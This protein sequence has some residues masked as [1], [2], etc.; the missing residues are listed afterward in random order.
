MSHFLF[1]VTNSCSAACGYCYARERSATHASPDSLEQIARGLLAETSIDG[2]T[3]IGGE[4]LE[5]PDIVDIAKRLTALG[6]PL[7][8][9]TNGLALDSSRLEA[10]MAAGLRTFE[11]SL[12]T[13]DAEIFTALGRGP[14]VEVVKHR[15]AELVRS[16][17]QVTVSAVLSRMNL[18]GIGDLVEFCFAVGATGLSLLRVLRPGDATGNSGL[19][20]TSEAL[21]EALLRCDERAGALDFP[22][23]CSIPVEPCYFPTRKLEHLVLPACECGNSKWVVDPRGNLRTCELSSLKLGNLLNTSFS[24]LRQDACATSFRQRNQR[25]HCDRCRHLA[26][27]GGGCRFLE[28]PTS[29]DLT[30]DR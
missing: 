3:L 21:F 20:P 6:L 26:Q 8:M 13:I 27:C 11:V 23:A 2:V 25:S 10:L 19:A 9:T 14:D 12:D 29:A 7:A 16:G 28:A 4:P 5:H 30:C 22:V 1:E 15:I 18:A 24:E 17:A